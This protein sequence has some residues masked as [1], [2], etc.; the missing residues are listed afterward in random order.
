MNGNPGATENCHQAAPYYIP[1]RSAV[2]YIT[3]QSRRGLVNGLIGSDRQR[4]SISAGEEIDGEYD[5]H[6]LLPWPGPIGILI[7]LTYSSIAFG[8]TMPLQAK[9]D[10]TG[11]FSPMKLRAS[12]QA[13]LQKGLRI[14]G[15]NTQHRQMFSY[16][17]R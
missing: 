12:L 17:W 8:I 15:N 3:A 14:K 5:R 13:S 4:L 6:D 7:I 2:V 11:R 16:H 9:L 10:Q 1:N